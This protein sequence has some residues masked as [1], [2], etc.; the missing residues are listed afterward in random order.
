MKKL[1]SGLLILV[2]ITL[3]QL[4]KN[5]IVANFSLGQVK[6]FIPNVLSLTYLKN[7]GAAWSSFSGQQWFFM[8]LTPLVLIVAAYFF[9][10]NMPIKTG[11]I[12]G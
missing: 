7:D 6:T 9:Y 2:G 11:I 12:G 3:D 8:L 4:F 5:W 10:G 1:I